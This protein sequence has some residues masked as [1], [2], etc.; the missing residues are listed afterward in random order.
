MLYFHTVAHHMPAEGGLNAQDP[1]LDI[2]WP[3][4]VSERSP[5]D[6]AHPFLSPDFAGISL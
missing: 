5:R 3:L 2:R 4:P 1:A 6:A